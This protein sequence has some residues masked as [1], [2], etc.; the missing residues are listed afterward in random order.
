M[1]PATLRQKRSAETRQLILDTAYGLFAARGYGQTSIDAIIAAASI[2]KGALYHHF[3]SKEDVL[4]ALMQLHVRECGEQM[5]DAV[6][7]ATSLK[8]AAT[9]LAQ[10][11][12]ESL[13]ND[14]AWLR[15]FVEFWLQATRDPEARQVVARSME[16]CRELI[17][18]MLRTGQE[19]GAVRS[20]LDVAAA[21][22]IL[23]GLFDGVAMQS[24][25]DPAAVNIEQILQPMAEIIQRFIEQPPTAKARR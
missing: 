10:V 1:P 14:P 19:A 5:A 3:D 17:A 15:V 11:S 18:G 9:A 12:V 16:H 25:I 8:A 13:K 2:S 7:S 23:N 4:N 20:D 24:E 22:A 6:G 21:A